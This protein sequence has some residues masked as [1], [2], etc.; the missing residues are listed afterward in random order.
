MNPP[1]PPALRLPT[2]L[3]DWHVARLREQGDDEAMAALEA[4]L[5]GGRHG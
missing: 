3:L 4:L 2:W 5:E 1:C